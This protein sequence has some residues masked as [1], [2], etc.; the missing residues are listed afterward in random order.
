MSPNIFWINF[1]DVDYSEKA[2][3][4]TLKLTDGSIHTGNTVKE[5]KEATPFTFEGIQ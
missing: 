1:D 3:V 2:T 4:K 5:F